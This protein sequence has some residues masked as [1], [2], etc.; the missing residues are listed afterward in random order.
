MLDLALLPVEGAN[1]ITGFL[2]GEVD[3]GSALQA[4]GLAG[5][6]VVDRPAGRLRPHVMPQPRSGCRGGRE[7]LS[8]AAQEARA[9]GRFRG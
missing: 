8:H 6:G 9:T 2:E 3:Q 4:H 7:D 1:Q 5:G